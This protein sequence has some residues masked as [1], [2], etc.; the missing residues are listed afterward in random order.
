MGGEEFE[1]GRGVKGIEGRGREQGKGMKERVERQGEERRACARENAPQLGAQ[2]A[3]GFPGACGVCLG[4][5]AARV[6]PVRFGGL[7][8]H[9]G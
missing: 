2:V 5:C 9:G 3:P 4:G 7:D 6:L 1:G 8:I